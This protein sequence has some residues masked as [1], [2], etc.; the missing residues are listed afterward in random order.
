MNITGLKAYQDIQSI[1]NPKGSTGIEAP[2]GIEK[3]D[4]FGGF[5]KE[6]MGEVSQLQVKADQQ[7]EGLVANKPGVTAHEA[8]ISME[9]ADVA[10]Q[11]MNAVRSKIIRAY[12]EVLRTQV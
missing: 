10:F 7:I 9:K 8:M 1:V 12:E 2:K 5:L 6:A 3:Q 4:G 11:L